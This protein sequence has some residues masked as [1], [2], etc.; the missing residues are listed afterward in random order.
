MRVDTHPIRH[1]A[2][3][4]LLA[5]QQEILHTELSTQQ[6]ATLLFSQI[7]QDVVEARTPSV[8]PDSLQMLRACHTPDIEFVILT[9]KQP[10]PVGAGSNTLSFEFLLVNHKKRL[11]QLSLWASSKT[12]MGGALR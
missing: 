9:F 12:M 7:S 3:K 1:F 4:T 11:V 6:K 5:V 10:C 8:P 2:A